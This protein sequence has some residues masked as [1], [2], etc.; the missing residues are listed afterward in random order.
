MRVSMATAPAYPDQPNEDFVAASPHG[1]VLLDGAGLSGNTTK[2]VHGVAWYARRLGT[3]LLA[4]L[5]DEADLKTI[6]ATAICEIAESHA[7]TCNPGDDPAT[8]SSTVIVLRRAGDAI[9]YLVLADS[10]LVLDTG[11]DPPIV[12]TDDREAK[13][14]KRYRARMDALTNGTPEH[15]EARRDYVRAV[16]AH[17]NTSGGFWVAAANP[18]AAEHAIAGSYPAKFVRAAALLSDGASRLADWFHL[19]GWRGLLSIL[20]SQG[21]NTLIDQVR[22]AEASDPHGIR[23]PR[24]KTHDDATVAYCTDV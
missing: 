14:G 13:I 15:D 21:P 8:P 20:D 1:V 18:E 2:C 23:W 17:R 3:A 4:R 24:G 22:D 12:I 19:T 9:E 10:V 7:E 5:T 6:L 16:Q 11:E